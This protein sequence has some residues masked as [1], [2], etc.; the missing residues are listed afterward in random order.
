MIKEFDLVTLNIDIPEKHLKKGDEGTVVFIYDN[1]QGYEVEFFNKEGCTDIVLT[2]K[3]SH[4]K[5]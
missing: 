1:H 3:P 2:L 4:V 5:K